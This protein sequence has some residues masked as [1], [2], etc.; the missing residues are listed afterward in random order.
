MALTVE[1]RLTGWDL[2]FPG[3]ILNE[4]PYST[5]QSCLKVLNSCPYLAS[6]LPGRETAKDWL[7]LLLLKGKHRISAL[8]IL[9][10]EQME[11]QPAMFY[12]AHSALKILGSSLTWAGGVREVE[13]VLSTCSTRQTYSSVWLRSG[14]V[15][16]LLPLGSTCGWGWRQGTDAP[17]LFVHLL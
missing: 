16:A 11:S 10:G 9:V 3:H 5:I 15:K 7:P 1:H 12:C 14:G 17:I 8:P 6:E 4:W 2:S 13:T